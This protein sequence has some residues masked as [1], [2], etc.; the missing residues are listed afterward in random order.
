M[1]GEVIKCLDLQHFVQELI[2]YRKMNKYP[3]NNKTQH[4]NR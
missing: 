3:K 1:R 4:L 2:R